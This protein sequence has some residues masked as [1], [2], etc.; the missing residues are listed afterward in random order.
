MIFLILFQT[1]F[2][3]GGFFANAAQLCP[4][5]S[6]YVHKGCTS[7]ALCGAVDGAGNVVLGFLC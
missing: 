1:P 6:A 4:F 5:E 7:T 2:F 3:Q